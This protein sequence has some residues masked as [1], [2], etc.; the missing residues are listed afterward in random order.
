[1]R[2]NTS[3]VFALTLSIFVTG[4][5]STLAGYK[6]D[7][8]SNP[9][10]YHSVVRMSFKDAAAVV[11]ELSMMQ[12]SDY[13]PHHLVIKENYILWGAE[14]ETSAYV[15]PNG[16]LSVETNDPSERIYF[17]SIESIAIYQKKLGGAYYVWVHCKNIDKYVYLSQDLNEVKRFVDALESLRFQGKTLP[18]G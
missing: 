15:A 4:C 18:N 6:R 14:V 13:R 9:V 5:S 17:N 7:L 10:G 3:I 1:M 2:I 16:T 11:E 8:L 12:A